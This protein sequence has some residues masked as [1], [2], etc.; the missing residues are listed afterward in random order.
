[1]KRQYMTFGI[2]I[3]IIKLELLNYLSIE[4]KNF[5]QKTFHVAIVFLVNHMMENVKQ[6]ST[7]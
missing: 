4:V 1:M 2:A 5:F 7:K 6:A 3:Y